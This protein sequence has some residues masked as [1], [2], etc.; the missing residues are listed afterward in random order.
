VE[1]N[2][3]ETKSNAMFFIPGIVITVVTFP[4]IIVHELAH[5]LFCRLYKIPVFKVVYFQTESPAGYVLHETPTNKWHSVMISI[6]PFFV[7]TLLG[8]LIALPASLPVFK[9]NTATP[10]DYVLIYLGVSIA[11]HAFP[12]T[13]DAN[14]IWDTLKEKTTPLWVK[15][16]GYPIVGIIY[17][18]AI[19]SFFW[20]D[21][22]YGVAIAIG[23]PN[24][25]IYLLSGYF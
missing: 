15:I 14:A 16:A 22:V 3:S 17:L 7:N 19:G 1:K 23:L 10:L 21:L 24:L 8:G 13:G 18:G 20:L 5:Q 6:G 12:S 9:F 4:G 25:L 2:F 11:M